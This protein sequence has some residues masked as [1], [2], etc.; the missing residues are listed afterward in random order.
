M[1]ITDDKI[2]HRSM[3]STCNAA[4]QI[5]KTGSGGKELCSFS[6]I[7]TAACYLKHDSRTLFIILRLTA[8]QP[9]FTLL[10]FFYSGFPRYYEGQRTGSQ[11]KSSLSPAR[12]RCIEVFFN[13]IAGSQNIVCYTKE[14][15]IYRGSFHI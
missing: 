6:Q 13:G 7:R 8:V 12:L 15:V 10:F 9:R 4:W 5:K 11:S 2:D 14:F 3:L 1:K